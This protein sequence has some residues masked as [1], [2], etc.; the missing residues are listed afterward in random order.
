MGVGAHL[1]ALEHLPL[2]QALER[3]ALVGAHQLH[4]VHHA[5]VAA[6]QLLDLHDAGAER[7]EGD[8][9]A[10]AQRGQGR[11]L[12]GHL[13]LHGWL[14]DTLCRWAMVKG[15]AEIATSA[16]ASTSNQA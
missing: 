4:Q 15:G 14:A 12:A 6:A 13:M 2:L 5:H 3:K 16:L 1:V 9:S 7:G 8:R 10:R 11:L